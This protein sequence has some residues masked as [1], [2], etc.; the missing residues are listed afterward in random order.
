MAVK[1]GR[2]SCVN[3]LSSYTISESS[4]NSDR[5]KDH[6]TR[7]GVIRDRTKT[8]G[9]GIVAVTAGFIESTRSP[10]N[11]DA[12]FNEIFDLASLPSEQHRQLDEAPPPATGTWLPLKRRNP[13]MRGAQGRQ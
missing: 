6:S 10:L 8:F 9:S 4:T 13:R 3:K 11:L 12:R 5:E 1:S 2:L 7:W